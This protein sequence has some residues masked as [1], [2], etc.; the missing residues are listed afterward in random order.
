MTAP[1]LLASGLRFPE[2]PAFAPD[3]ALWGVEL[4][5]G[6]LFRWRDGTLDR[7][8][9][10]GRPNGL[11]FHDDA[12]FFCDAGRDSV[13]R[14]DFRTGEPDGGEI[15]AERGA[16]VDFTGPNDLAFS[17]SGTLVFTCP[18]D[19]RFEP[20]GAVWARLPG[21]DLQ[22]VAS[23]LRFPNGLAFTP[24][25]RDLIVAETFLHRLWRGRW[26]DHACAWVEAAPWVEIGGPIGPDGMAFGPDGKL[27]VAL[28]GQGCVKV[29]D[30]DGRI[31]D[32]VP[33][34]G[35][36][37]T[38]VAFDPSGVLGLVVTEAENGLLLSYP[39]VGVA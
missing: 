34:P 2:G 18:G 6:A 4:N 32:D 31:V 21:G 30:P 25:G 14:L 15:I 38:N 26:D 19:S 16:G 3:G 20:T 33:V 12:L 10:G 1:R 11:A 24:D 23:H 37:P 5:G 9:V 28:Y 36:R 22:Q 13:R 8:P 7:I 29:V 35:P 27:Y 39:G 17:P